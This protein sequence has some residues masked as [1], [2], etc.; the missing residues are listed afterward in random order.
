M[1]FL[2]VRRGGDP[3]E[4][5]DVSLSEDWGSSP[6]AKTSFEVFDVMLG[7]Y[8]RLALPVF[9]IHLRST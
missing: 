1:S 6:R 2:Y 8:L 7:V 5:R 4:R 3:K 9:T